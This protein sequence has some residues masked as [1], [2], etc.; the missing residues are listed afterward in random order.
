MIQSIAH[1]AVTVRNME[2]SV[3]F[4]T[5]ALGFTKAFEIPHPETGC[6]W[7]VYL[8][9]GKGQFVE[10]FYG[11]TTENPWNDAQ[12]GFNHLCFAVE[13]IHAAAKQ[14]RDAGYTL[15]VEP[16]EGCD[17][18]WQAWTTDPNGIRVELMQMD[19]RS[20]HWKFL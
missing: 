4:Y 3:R 17:F 11:G 6:P 10:L 20:P 18:N 1:A 9:A 15:D 19:P 5:E 14:V 16:M 12:I 2:E 13:D 7:I 8:S